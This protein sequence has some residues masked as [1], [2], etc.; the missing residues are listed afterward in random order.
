MTTLSKLIMIITWNGIYTPV[1]HINIGEKTYI[2]ATNFVEKCSL[3]FNQ[4][5]GIVFNSDWSDPDW[6]ILLQ[7][8]KISTLNNVLKQ[9]ANYK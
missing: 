7:S 4:T 3:V 9:Y 8:R 1:G 5:E 6:N 2:L